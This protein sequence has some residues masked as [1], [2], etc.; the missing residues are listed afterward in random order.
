[1]HLCEVT[2]NI[3]WGRVTEAHLRIRTLHLDAFMLPF[4]LLSIYGQV[5]SF[6]NKTDVA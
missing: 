1:M 5:V 3:L 4:A 6:L 2:G